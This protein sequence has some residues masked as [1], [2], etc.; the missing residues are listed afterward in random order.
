MRASEPRTVEPEK[1]APRPKVVQQ[2]KPAHAVAQGRTNVRAS[3]SIESG[4]VTQLAPN[5]K[6][7]VQPSAGDWFQVKPRAGK[8]FEGYIRRDR[9]V[10]E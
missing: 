4:V 3:A 10:F 8:P 9:F 5:Q 2:W 6:I 1:A 7:L